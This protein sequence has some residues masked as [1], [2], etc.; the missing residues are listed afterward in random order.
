MLPLVTI[1]LNV[2]RELIEKAMLYTSLTMCGLVKAP[3]E[4]SID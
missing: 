3:V 1:L 4:M 2:K